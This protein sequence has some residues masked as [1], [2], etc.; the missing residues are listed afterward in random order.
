MLGTEIR[1]LN[2]QQLRERVSGL[3]A[4]VHAELQ[5]HG[6]CTTRQLAERCG[7]DLLTVRPRVTE[8]EQLGFAGCTGREKGEGVY[9]AFNY[10]ESIRLF[11]ERQA[12]ARGEGV[13]TSFL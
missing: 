7:I 6:P 13:Q 11:H 8:L 2:W 1:D 12:I 9:R 10:D 5:R 3:R 4:I